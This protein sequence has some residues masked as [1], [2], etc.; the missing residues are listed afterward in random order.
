HDG[1]RLRSAAQRGVPA[2]YA[3]YRERHPPELVGGAGLADASRTRRALQVA[4]MKAERAY[5]DGN[6]NIRAM[7]DLG[8]IRTAVA[9]PLCKDECVFGVLPVFRQE[10]RPFPARRVVLRENFAAEAVIA[11]ENAG[12]LNE[13]RGA[14]EQQT[15]T[16][17]VLQVIN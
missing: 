14:L 10:G 6:P 12:L 5:L 3:A 2:A 4:D 7:V 17:E 9:V 13:Q 8:G 11:M 15:A 1:D 16:A